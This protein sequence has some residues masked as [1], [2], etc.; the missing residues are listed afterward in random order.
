MGALREPWGPVSALVREIQ[1]DPPNR[2][3]SNR[4]KKWG[5]LGKKKLQS[6]ILQEK[7]FSV[8]R[9][10]MFRKESRDTDRVPRGEPRTSKIKQI[11]G[12]RECVNQTPRLKMDP[13]RLRGLQYATP[14]SRDRYHLR[15]G[16][17]KNI[18]VRGT[19]GKK[20]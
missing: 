10:R 3:S 16:K 4:Q 19:S 20:C 11:G 2:G 18:S 13:G 5:G 9:M 7:G 12:G 17:I 8:Q 6:K 15:V 14:K 1:K